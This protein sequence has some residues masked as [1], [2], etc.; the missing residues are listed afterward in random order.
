MRR[1]RAPAGR[2]VHLRTTTRARV[3]AGRGSLAALAVVVGPG[4]L[5]GLSDDDPAG[6]TT[7]SILGARF[8]YRMLWVLAI[9]TV[10]LIVF[11]ELTARMGVVT[12]KVLMAL[13]RE[14][15]GPRATAL[16]ISALVIA[17]VGTM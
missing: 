11:H 9:S 14:C 17:N 8:G 4:L 13:V 5:A 12:G 7:Y 15:Y 3:A 16:A 10:A 2:H 6:I 1:P